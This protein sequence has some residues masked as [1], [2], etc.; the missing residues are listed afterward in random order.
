MMSR[1][2]RVRRQHGVAEIIGAI[3]LVAL[4]IVAGVI[5]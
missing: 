2:W 1:R 4:T 3:L 5:L